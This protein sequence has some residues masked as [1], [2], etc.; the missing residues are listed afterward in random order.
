M[1]GCSRS[2]S[3]SGCWRAAG[4]AAPRPSRRRRSAPAVGAGAPDRPGTAL[5]SARHGTGRRCLRAGARGAVRRARRGVRG[6]PCG[7]RARRH[8]DQAARSTVG[9]THLV[10]RLLRQPGDAGSDG[11]GARPSRIARVGL[12]SVS[13]LG[14]A[15]LAGAA[16]VV[17]SACAPL[18]HGVRR[19]APV[20]GSPGRVPLT[21]HAE[22]VLEVGP[23]VPPH[24]AYTFPQDRAIRRGWTMCRMGRRDFTWAL[25]VFV[26]LAFLV[27]PGVASAHLRT[28]TIAVDYKTSVRTPVTAAYS[29][30]IYQSDHGLT[31]TLRPGHVVVLR[32]IS[33]SRCS[34]SIA[35]GCGSMPR[36]PPPSR[37]ACCTS[38]R[39]STRRLR[40]GACRAAG[41]PWRGTTRERR[42]SRRV[43]IRVCGDCR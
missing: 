43:L 24:S 2:G 26:V 15:A 5:S 10:R 18:D 37:R 40:V 7:D 34:V 22:I 38:R 21:R 12:G 25:A 35:R 6:Q 31:L 29:A 23:Y 41:T 4:R 14:P 30:R 19:R 39:R 17:P 28:G 42:D 1:H 11:P 32:A 16:R 20:N 8:R 33:A 13:R 3:E 9:G 36:H 27:G